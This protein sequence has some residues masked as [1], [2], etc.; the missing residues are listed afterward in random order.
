VVTLC[1][2]VREV[3]PEFPGAREQIHWSV[4]DPSAERSPLAFERAA[5]EIETRA[6]FLI[7]TINVTR[8]E[9][10]THA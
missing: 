9:V 3:C 7:A 1:D 6:G 4:P 10:M 5:A 8:Q 2:R